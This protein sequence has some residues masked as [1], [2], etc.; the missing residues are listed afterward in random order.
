MHKYTYIYTI[1]QVWDM[2]RN[3]PVDD[4]KIP[5]DMNGYQEFKHAYFETKHSIECNRCY[6]SFGLYCPF[7]ELQPQP[8][9][10][11]KTLM[12]SIIRSA[13]LNSVFGTSS[14]SFTLQDLVKKYP[15]FLRISLF[16]QKPS[17]ECEIQFRSLYGHELEKME[18]QKES[19][20]TTS[21]NHDELNIHEVER[22]KYVCEDAWKALL[23]CFIFTVP[24]KMG[25]E[26]LYSSLDPYLD[27]DCISVISS[28]LT[29]LDEMDNKQMM[30]GMD[31]FHCDDYKHPPCP[32]PSSSS[33]SLSCFC[34]NTSC[35]SSSALAVSSQS[36]HPLLMLDSSSRSWKRIRC[37]GFSSLFI[38]VFV[39]ILGCLWF[40]KD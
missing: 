22:R 26:Y 31:L 24:W 39:L 4:I 3:E 6:R 13:V 40:F 36:F 34:T 38:L 28:Y 21:I 5:F 27:R 8:H 11:K 29:V 1:D 10:S 32:C 9:H 17:F 16:K 12:S 19:I 25:Q 2:M 30:M 35:C 18:I 7:L 33:S 20:I 14:H 23:P 37:I 15:C